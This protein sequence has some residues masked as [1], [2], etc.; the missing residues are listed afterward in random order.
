MISLKHFKN[1]GSPV[2]NQ[3]G[4]FMEKKTIIETE[5]LILRGFEESDLDNYYELISNENVYKWLG[6]RQ[7]KSREE[8]KNLL[9]N[10]ISEF[11]KNGIG[12]LAV[13]A[14]ES[15]KLIGKAGVKYIREF[16]AIEYLYALN[17]RDWNK[18]YATEIGRNFI[19]HY[20]RN[21]SDD[22]LIAIVYPDNIGSKKV[23]TK[24]GFE[25]KGQKE[26]F[27]TML[28]YYELI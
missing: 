9:S 7:R 6:N 3:G 20:R 5:R 11:S 16:D 18:G 22:K 1:P 12:V 14:K 26:I 21:V 17:Y 15:G 25:L 8:A 28:D 24:L 4:A 23:L 13:I 2:T 19:R 27:G 10:F